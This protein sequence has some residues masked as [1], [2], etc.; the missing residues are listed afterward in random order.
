MESKPL[1][2]GVCLA[3]DEDG[4]SLYKG[5]PLLRAGVEPDCDPETFNLFIALSEH[6]QVYVCYY[7]FF[8]NKQ[9]IV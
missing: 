1:Q 3:S 4:R 2:P 5:T 8:K 7:F 6:K 9:H